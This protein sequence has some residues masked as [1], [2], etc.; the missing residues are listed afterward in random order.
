MRDKNHL[1]YHNL[2]KS[3]SLTYHLNKKQASF[4]QLHSDL[5]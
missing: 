3:T 2:T 4:L 1:L 5:S